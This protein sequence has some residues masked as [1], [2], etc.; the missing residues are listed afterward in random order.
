MKGKTRSGSKKNRMAAAA[1]IYL[2]IRILLFASLLVGNELARDQASYIDGKG[3]ARGL[4]IYLA[5]P[6]IS[7]GMV[8]FLS[9]CLKIPSGNR[10]GNDSGTSSGSVVKGCAAAAAVCAVLLYWL[11]LISIPF[12]GIDSMTERISYI[13]SLGA[14]AVSLV[15]VLVFFL[16]ENY[17]KMK[18]KREGNLC[19]PDQ[20]DP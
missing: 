14:S 17:S 6:G 7:S 19:C 8:L 12:L 11:S 13:C 9:A 2:G 3:L 4:L 10:S 18:A 16:M 5:I 1:G 15:L 20:V